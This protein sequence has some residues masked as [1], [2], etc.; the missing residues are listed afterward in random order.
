MSIGESSCTLCRANSEDAEFPVSRILYERGQGRSLE[1][2]VAWGGEF[3][4]ALTWLKASAVKGT[5]AL[6]EYKA[7]SKEPVFRA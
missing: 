1:Y 4:G 7:R 2:Q 5:A 3:T 6:L